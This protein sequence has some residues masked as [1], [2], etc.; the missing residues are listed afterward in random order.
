MSLEVE[1]E[2]GA[3]KRS[4]APY[5]FA[6]MDAAFRKAGVGIAI[7][8]AQD[9]IIRANPEFQRITGYPERELERLSIQD[10][11]HPED[12][13]LEPNERRRWLRKSGEAVEVRVRQMAHG[14][15]ANAGERMAIV[16]DLSDS[17]RELEGLRAAAEERSEA[18]FEWD[19]ITD[20]VRIYGA[21][22]IG[23]RE[24]EIPTTF[25]DWRRRIH[26]ADLESVQQAIGRHFE[27]REPMAVRY[28]ISRDDG[29]ESL[30]EARGS[31]FRNSAGDCSLWIG[32]ITNVTANQPTDEIA[33]LAAIVEC[34]DDAI[35]G[36][37]PDCRIVSWNKGAE[38]L[39]GYSAAEIIGRPLTLLTS[40]IPGRST[41]EPG[42]A[43]V[44][45]TESVHFTKN[46]TCP[47]SV[48]MSPVQREDGS[49]LGFSLVSRDISEH[50][51]TERRLVHQMLHDTLTGLPN[52]RFLRENLDHAIS[53]AAGHGQSVGVFFIDIDGFKTINE[54]LGH[55]TGDEL[56][57]SIAARLSSC[58]RKA[59][60][61]GRVGGDEFVL[62]VTGLHN[63]HSARLV[64]TKIIDTLRA[65]FLISGNEVYLAASIGVSLFP[66]D[67][68]DADSL[69]RNA[70][71]A[72]CE[73]KRGGKNQVNFFTRALSDALRERMEIAGSL[74]LALE[75]EEFQLHFQ[76]VFGT[77][78]HRILR[79]EA[80]LRWRPAGGME[81]SPA[82]FIPISEET[83]WI[84]PIGQWVLQEACRRAAL[85]QEGPHRGI[86]V[87][88]NVSAVQLA[89]PEFVGMLAQVLADSG[90]PPALLELELTES[91]FINNPRET[92]RTIS[93]VHSLGVTMALDD[94][95]TGYSSLGYLKNLPMDALKIDKS[96][97]GGVG[98]D[99]SA[100]VLVESLISLAHSLGM[101]VVVEGVET[102]EQFALLNALGCDELQGF[103]LGRPSA[104]L[105][106]HALTVAPEFTSVN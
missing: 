36:C 12:R 19:T 65:P 99:A 7:I 104:E 88:V 79:F 71:A 60:M 48:T 31:A 38:R 98:T 82:K 8:D 30:M 58:A 5:P 89:R 52:R 13:K 3:Q 93:R 35:I 26:A 37:D 18:V 95:G 28:R 90:L 57:R 45:R 42:N 66:E 68:E 97:L 40:E 47:V 73:A 75:K 44:R 56:L 20:H 77:G 102:G 6:E 94:F 81:V 24:S 11:A 23:L 76:P 62:I 4:V 34:C 61:L 43:M 74:R 15:G 72:M 63:R 70:D 86:G 59:D 14:D 17:Q 46:G 69:M 106:T 21:A 10:L 105:S 1:A 41:S 32:V 53:A 67:T 103:L 39:Y 54:T 33:R 80:L 2:S 25:A 78:G 87:S 49:V 84:V 91:I 92:A 27:T 9:R 96:F 29:S 16:E 51:R 55:V 101:R 64:A 100:A 22:R 50:K 83:G 85:W